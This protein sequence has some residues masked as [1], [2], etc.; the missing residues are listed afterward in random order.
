MGRDGKLRRPDA[1]VRRPTNS[2]EALRPKAERVVLNALNDVAFAIWI[3]AAWATDGHRLHE[4]PIHLGRSHTCLCER[5][6]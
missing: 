1:L 4:K 5:A 2:C 3:A 6:R